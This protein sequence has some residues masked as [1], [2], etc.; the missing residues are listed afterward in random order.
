MANIALADAYTPLFWY[1][2]NAFVTADRARLHFFPVRGGCDDEN[3]LQCVQDYDFGTLN[4][5]ELESEIVEDDHVMT[6]L[7][8]WDDGIE[9]R[10][11][12]FGFNLNDRDN[13]GEDGEE[14]V[15]EDADNYGWYLDRVTA[16]Y[17]GD[18]DN[19]IE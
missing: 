12:G 15:L 4:D 10:E 17:E 18:E 14:E 8:G 2:D 6:L 11:L 7:G 1:A 5:L 13:K 19:D 3:N 9:D 16:S